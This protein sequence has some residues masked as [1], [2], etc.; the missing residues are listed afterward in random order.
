MEEEYD[1]LEI[2][3]VNVYVEKKSPVSPQG[4][5]VNLKGFSSFKRLVVDGFVLY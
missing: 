5:E 3:G 2:S 1:K 4:L